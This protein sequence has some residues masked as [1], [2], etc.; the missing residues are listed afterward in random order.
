MVGKKGKAYTRLRPSGKIEIE[1]A[2]YDAFTRGNF[3]EE[4]VS[5]EVISDEGTSLKVKEVQA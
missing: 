4:G 1:G 2:T 3:I 5:I